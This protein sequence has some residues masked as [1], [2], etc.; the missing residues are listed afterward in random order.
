[1]KSDDEAVISRSA[2]FGFSECA[3]LS[4][5][6]KD[7]EKSISDS[8]KST[9]EFKPEDCFTDNSLKTIRKNR[10]EGVINKEK[11]GKKVRG[12]IF[13]KLKSISTNPRIDPAP[14]LCYN[15]CNVTDQ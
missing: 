6:N 5:E 7:Y 2:N 15:C 8:K 10:N 13:G 4:I 14:R 9:K 11:F 1:M 3:S 12:I